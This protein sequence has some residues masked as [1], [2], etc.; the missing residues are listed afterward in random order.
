M[1]GPYQHVIHRYPQKARVVRSLLLK[2]Q[3]FRGICEEYEAARKAVETWSR[4]RDGSAKLRAAEFEKI[5][6]ELEVE[7]E[8]VLD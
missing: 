5:S 1:S 8:R 3:R 7:I 4:S 2:D 6:R